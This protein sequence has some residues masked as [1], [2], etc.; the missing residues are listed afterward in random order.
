MCAQDYHILAAA[1]AILFSMSVYG[2]H[3]TNP[4]FLKHAFQFLNAW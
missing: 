2:L 3:L 1:A 4:T